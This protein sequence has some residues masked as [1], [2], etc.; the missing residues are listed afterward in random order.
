MTGNAKNSIR[1][2]I[3]RLIFAVIAAAVAVA[4]IVFVIAKRPLPQ[5]GKTIGARLELVAGDVSVKEGEAATKALSGT[6]LGFGAVVSTGKGSRAFVRTGE[7]AG[8][9]LRGESEVVLG[10]RSVDLNRGE[11]WFDAARVE[12]DA[13]GCKAGAH[14]VT[15]SDAG[16]S[17]A[18]EGDSVTVYVARGLATLNSPGGRVEVNAG[19]QATAKGGEAPKVSPVAFWQDWTGGMGD[20]RAAR[21]NVGS[22]SGRI[23]GLDPFAP[24]ATPATKLG[25]SK[26]VVRSVIRDGVAETEVDQTFSNPGGRAIE[27]WYWFTLPVQASVTSFALETDG[28]LVEGEVTEK[29][30]AA[31]KYAAAVR[32]ANDPAL[33]E[34]VDGRSYRARIFP[35]PA[36]GVRRVVLRY[37]EILPLIEGK[38]RYVYPLRSDDPVRFDEFALSVDL[39]ASSADATLATSLD[40]TVEDNGRKVSMRRSGYVPKADFQLEIASKKK[41]AALR[42]WRFEAGSDQADYVMARYVPDVDFAT[43][44]A[45]R[46]DIALV[47]DTSA[48]GDESARALRA[49]AAEAILRAL[50]PDDRFALISVDV[51]ATVL[52]PKDGM[53]PATD[54]DIAQALERLSEHTPAGATDLAAMFEP[55]LARLH[56]GEQPAIVYVGDGAPTSGEWTPDA[57]TERL[58]RS[59]AGSRS[60]LF[61]VGVGADARHSLMEHLSRTGGGRYVRIAE[62]DQTTSQALQLASLIKTPT[63]TD[64][65]VDMGAGLDQPFYSSAGRISRGEELILLARTHHRLPKTATVKGRVAGKDFKTDYQ[66]ETVSSVVTALVPRLWAGE[67]ARQLLGSGAS[68]DENRSKVL[69]LGLEYGL[70]TPYT[71]ILALES[72]QA[73][74]RQNVK[75]RN[76]PLRGVR[77]TAIQSDV[78]EQRLA[79][80]FNPMGPVVMAGCGMNRSSDEAAPASAPDDKQ[81]GTGTRAKGEEGSMGNPNRRYASQAP[82]APA[83]AEPPAEQA[84]ATANNEVSGE[85]SELDKLDLAT[86]G[87]LGGAAPPAATMAPGG[88]Q[89]LGGLGAKGGGAAKARPAEPGRTDDLPAAGDKKAKTANAPPPPPKDQL[90]QA[91]EKAEKERAEKAKLAATPPK[92]ITVPKRPPARC[93]DAAARPLAERIMLW[94]RRLKGVTRGVDLMQQYE[95][96]RQGCELPDWKDQSALLDIIQKRIETEES[97]EAVLSHFASESDAQ[98]FVARRVLRRTVDLRVAAA[99]SR[100]LFGG[101]VDWAQVD[102]ELLDTPKIA[103]KLDKLRKA[104]LIAPGD[105]SG[106]ARLVRLLAESGQVQE[107]VSH[108]RR[109]RDRGFMTPLL[110]L[111]LGDQLAATNEKDEALRTYSEIVEF[112]PANPASRRVLGD[113]FLRHGWYPAAYRQYRTLADLE[114]KNPVNWLRLASAAAGSGRIDEALRLEREVA[115]GEGSPGPNDPRL[116]ARM[117]SAARLGLLLEDPTPAGG[118]QA[119]DSIVRKLKELQ[120]FSGPGTLALLTW[121]DLDANL[122]LA[123]READ[124]DKLAG[125]VTDAGPTGLH[126]MLLGKEAWER[127]SWSVKWRNDPR[128]RSVKFAL[129]ELDWNGKAFSVKVRRGELKPDQTDTPI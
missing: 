33:L 45:V 15:A 120:L 105:P 54:K 99:V 19:E 40:A 28:V 76:S 103:D 112:D 91:K 111:N 73:Y 10:D 85:K 20:T 62:P 118:K 126:A 86:V 71:S 106:D 37:I 64:V 46:G 109:L 48:G 30:E 87:A 70:M 18:R 128:G 98:K 110:A 12:R 5:K 32:A 79:E 1:N 52:Y 113:S 82:A 44:P 95:L 56:G 63:V 115:G 96:A 53:S 25:I 59:L 107:A 22:G 69:E 6:P 35:I 39:G 75:R 123:G 17:V 21:A 66:V 51:S 125:E 102:R 92:P 80:L 104:M 14:A 13:V 100:V 108:G 61:C 90:A 29:K 11:I 67:Y 89:G 77:L 97:V 31:A 58:S 23:Y 7:G 9:F 65:E 117:W 78:Q 55:A 93:S 83:A 24:P 34:W 114:P 41:M 60:R 26:Q 68:A 121:Q 4:I 127:T 57:L 43:L 116:W 88:G 72:E 36:N 16:L 101:K 27:G 84:Q 38:T 74:A 3:R 124:K 122:V 119:V 129:V 42:T 47:V 8:V 81:G 49:A 2:D 94:E 50:S